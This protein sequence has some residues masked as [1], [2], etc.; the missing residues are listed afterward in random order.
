MTPDAIKAPDAP[1]AVPAENSGATMTTPP[2]SGST[3][4]LHYPSAM[5]PAASAPPLKSPDMLPVIVSDYIDTTE[6][7][8]T[9]A[10]AAAQSAVT[11]DELAVVIAHCRHGLQTSPPTDTRR[12]LGRLAAWAHTRRGELLAEAGQTQP[13]FAEFEAALRLDENCALALHNRAVSFAQQNRGTEALRDFDRVIELNPG[14]AV[15]YRNRGELLASLGRLPEAIADYDRALRHVPT[16]VDLYRA[17]AEARQRLGDYDRALADLNRA[18][19]IAPDE[20]S[21]FVQRASL[22][23]H[24]GD[25]R[26]AVNDYQRAI[27]LA[28]QQTDGYRGLAWLLATCADP[29]YR[30]PE[31]AVEIAKRGLAQSRNAD[32]ALLDTLAAAFA[33]AGQFELA[34]GAA[35]RALAAAPP[36]LAVHMRHRLALYQQRQPYFEAQSEPQVMPANFEIQMPQN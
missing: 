13:A 7:W 15:A 16:D 32:P 18:L 25:F 21:I 11:I 24:Q 29:R 14:L 1:S 3:L 17:R 33:S 5:Q 20:A 19:G 36:E 35:Q 8:L 2:L 9:K 31:Q 28:P 30:D 10:E 23:A 34:A 12:S 27:D 26:A 4:Q 22:A 6:G